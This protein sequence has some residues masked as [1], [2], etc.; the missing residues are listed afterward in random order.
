MPARKAPRTIDKIA[1]LR[2]TQ[3]FADVSDAVVSEAAS[4]AVTR[5][6]KAGEVLFSEHDKASG[7]YI[8]ADGELR[9]VR[10]NPKGREQVL[11]TERA[12]AILAATSVFDG[13]N[14]YTTT[15]ADTD[16]HVL[17]ID[18]QDML[19][20]CHKY[21]E[22]L[23]AI[24]KVFA[25]KIRH[26]AQLVETLAL[27]NVDQR[28]AQHLLTA[29][30]ERGTREGDV[31]TV[32]LT[33]TQAELA[34]RIGSTREVVNRSI[35]HLVRDGLIQAVG[36]RTFEILSVKALSKFAGFDRELDDPPLISELSSELA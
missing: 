6:L 35:G 16:A 26:F 2:K 27:H 19:N 33:M 14:Y 17:C 5:Q 29:C 13:G 31:C 12:G 1:A 30:Q 21:T 8:V 25:H 34:S 9:S 4:L 18:T 10:Q 32:E 20:L 22:L 24:A 3:L 7:L 15:I 36:S 11:S 28:L 23:W